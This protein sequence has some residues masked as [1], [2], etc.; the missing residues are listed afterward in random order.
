VAF[1]LGALQLSSDC[2]SS[3]PSLIL[4]AFIFLSGVLC[5]HDLYG[6]LMLV[7]SIAIL[8]YSVPFTICT[9]VLNEIHVKILV[10]TLL[11]ACDPDP[12]PYPASRCVAT[13]LYV[14]CHRP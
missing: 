13:Q 4:Q 2:P 10:V 1:V 9:Q 6:H 7:A 11:Y 14:V 3:F 12:T 8:G 5:M